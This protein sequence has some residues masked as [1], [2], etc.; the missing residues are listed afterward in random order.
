MKVYLAIYAAICLIAL[1]KLWKQGRVGVIAIFAATFFTFF[2]GY[3][4]YIGVDWV[5]YEFIFLDNSRSSLLEALGYGDSAYSLINWIVSRLGGQVWH[6]N[7]LCAA[8]F[9]IALVTFCATLPRPGLAL[10]VAVPTLIIVTAMGYTRQATAIGCIM[11]AFSQFRGTLDLRWMAWLC[12]AILFHKSAII[13]FPIFVIT[14][15]QQRW[16]SITM[17]SAIALVILFTVVLQNVSDIMSLY[18]EGDIES[19]GTIPRVAVGALAGL[20]YFAIKTKT[21]FNERQALVRNMAIAMLALVPLYAIIPSTTVVDRIGILLVPFQCAILAGLAASLEKS[22]ISE[23]IITCLILAFY[24]IMYFV[25]LM[26]ASY[27]EY[28]IPYQNVLSVRWL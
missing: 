10:A 20:S 14:A 2:V 9:S 27:A 6:V 26:Y 7:L 16:L 25:W 23:A 4:Y 15:S 21:V 22:P 24:G 13:L 17:G 18:F 28:W 3:R 5:T 12:L 11:L 19:S 1:L 8:I